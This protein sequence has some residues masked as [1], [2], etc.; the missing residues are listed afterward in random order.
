[1][2]RTYCG[3]NSLGSPRIWPPWSLDHFR[4]PSLP[5]WRFWERHVS[6]STFSLVEEA[7][8][9]LTAVFVFVNLKTKQQNSKYSGD[10]KSDHLKSRL[11]E[12][13]ISNGWAQLSFGYSFS[14][15]HLKTGPFEIQT[16]LSRFQKVLNKITAICLEFKWLSLQISDLIQN[17]DHQK[18]RLV[19]KLDPHCIRQEILRFKLGIEI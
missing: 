9:N 7:G 1:M 5:K 2:S 6:V 12:G 11:F 8:E 10:V 4:E 18:S 17:P 16:L 13:L 3:R 19:L 15:N 14:P